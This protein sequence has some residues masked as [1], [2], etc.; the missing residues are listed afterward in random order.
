MFVPKLLWAGS[1]R[2]PPGSQSIVL[3]T[4]PAK[5]PAFLYSANA[6]AE[7][8]VGESS[9]EQT[10][11][12]QVRVLQGKG[13]MISLG[14]GGEGEVIE[15]QG[16]SIVSWSVRKVDTQRY[17]DLQWK[18]NEGEKSATVRIRTPW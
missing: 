3:S 18:E 10:I 11:Q 8:K 17:L 16:D 2:H 5:P 7:V 14:L 6:K 15:V 9:V 12:I 1:S 13:E 4:L